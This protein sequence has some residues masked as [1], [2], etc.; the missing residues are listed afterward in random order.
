MRPGVERKG[1]L[2]RVTS[3][4]PKLSA[5]RI[6]LSTKVAQLEDFTRELDKKNE[7]LQKSTQRTE[8]IIS[9]TRREVE[10]SKKECQ[11]SLD[12]KTRELETLKREQIR[13]SRKQQSL[14]T[15]LKNAQNAELTSVREFQCLRSAHAVELSRRDKTLKTALDDF[16]KSLETRKQ[17][18]LAT[19]K[20][21]HDE[22][23]SKQRTIHEK[24]IEKWRGLEKDRREELNRLK[25]IHAT[26]SSKMEESFRL[27]VA[28]RDIF[29]ASLSNLMD[30]HEASLIKLRNSLQ[31]EIGDLK[32]E[33][34]QRL[35]KKSLATSNSVPITNSKS[36]IIPVTGTSK[37]LF[38]AVRAPDFDA[39]TAILD[40][41]RSVST[42]ARR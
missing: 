4:Y 10:K 36:R 19:L 35:Q 38:F 6:Q 26:E 17:K 42:C 2:F 1:S 8:D 41:R 28:N 23:L 27:H 34:E 39:F 7:E 37:S 14:E 30:D 22:E 11:I 13:N 24:E 9:Q 3:T 18:Q 33:E 12:A 29:A 5:N 21:F 32:S 16:Q 15:Q 25:T 40:P 20:C 31:K